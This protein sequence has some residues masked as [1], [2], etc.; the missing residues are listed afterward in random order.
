MSYLIAAPEA[1]AAASADLEDVR[2]ALR[3]ANAAAP[4]A[5]ASSTGPTRARVSFTKGEGRL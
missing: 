3:A 2:A 4:T 1:L 5:P